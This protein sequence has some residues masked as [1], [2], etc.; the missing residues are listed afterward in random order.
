[1]CFSLRSSFHTEPRSCF[2]QKCSG[3]IFTNSPSLKNF[4]SR[5]KG[6]LENVDALELLHQPKKLPLGHGVDMW[7]SGP[8]IISVTKILASSDVRLCAWLPRLDK[9]MRWLSSIS[10]ADGNHNYIQDRKNALYFFISQFFQHKDCCLSYKLYLL[11]KVRFQVSNNH[12][13]KNFNLF[14]S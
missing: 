5:N 3:A 4:S 12:C 6:S 10:F 13:F 14:I 1:M 9:L 11:A 2:L 7:K 8:R